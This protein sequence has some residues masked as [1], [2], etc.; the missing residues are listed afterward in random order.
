M[1]LVKREHKQSNVGALFQG[2][3]HNR[4]PDDYSRKLHPLEQFFTGTEYYTTPVRLFRFF[5]KRCVRDQKQI[6]SWEGN[7]CTVW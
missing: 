5:C 1:A 2:H 6:V 4:G 3:A 7:L